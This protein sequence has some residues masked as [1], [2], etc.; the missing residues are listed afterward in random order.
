MKNFGKLVYEKKKIILL[1]PL[2]KIP[3]LSLNYVLD[4]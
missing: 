4:T 1:Q 3:F 2:N